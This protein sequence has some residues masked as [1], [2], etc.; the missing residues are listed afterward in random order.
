MLA[1]HPDAYRKIKARYND[2][3]D[4]GWSREDLLCCALQQHG[5]HG[6]LMHLRPGFDIG[7]IRAHV[8]ELLAKPDGRGTRARLL[9]TRGD[10]FHALRRQGLSPFEIVPAELR[11]WTWPPR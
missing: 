4:A 2:F 10:N 11:D 3:M 9:H 1:D 5:H 8:C 7:E 6:L